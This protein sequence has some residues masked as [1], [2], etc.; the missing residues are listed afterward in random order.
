MLTT[1][2]LKQ[3]LALIDECKQR[4]LIGDGG[5]R[6][7]LPSHWPLPEQASEDDIALMALAFCSQYPLL[8]Q[9][10]APAKLR[11][12]PALPPLSLPCLPSSQRPA[13]RQILGE[14]NRH[15]RLYQSLLW[16]MVSRNL[17]PH[18][19]D[20]LPSHNDT[21]LPPILTPWLGWNGN[22]EISALTA[23]T[24]GDFM[25][26]QRLAAMA[27]LR[28]QHPD[29]ARELLAAMAPAESA[30]KRYDLYQLLAVGLTADDMPLLESLSAD[31]SQKVK[32]LAARLKMRL[33]EQGAQAQDET[34][35]ELVGWLTLKSR[36]LLRRETQVLAPALK[37]SVQYRER[38]A[39]LADVPLPQ[40]AAGL[41]MDVDALL[42]QW[43]FA[44]NMGSHGQ[45]PN[46][47]LLGN[48]AASLPDEQVW[49]VAQSLMNMSWEQGYDPMGYLE[50]LA[51]RLAEEARVE[52]A[53]GLLIKAPADMLPSALCGLFNGEWRWLTLAVFSKSRA[54]AQLIKRV[55]KQAKSD[56][57][58]YQLINAMA[59]LGL[60]LSLECANW[61]LNELRDAGL[62]VMHP[63]LDHLKFNVSL[64]QEG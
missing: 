3:D 13:F 2:T 58:D 10:Q 1:D 52:L 55:K 50:I 45:S 36:G 31:R 46:R 57:L 37:N 6:L 63:M 29:T 9:P 24:W 30:E 17:V 12:L 22:S 20:W 51:P 41:G 27:E 35:T 16:L 26:A 40:L 38:C 47:S 60:C 14:L 11:A 42:S 33:G 28:R 8:E 53:N 64:K 21:D 39:A 5:L 44:D 19:Q 18:P 62:H 59:Q 56:E 61:L 4:W 49:A 32:E 34:L 43:A 25:P 54:T 23:D 15:D 48:V 7:A